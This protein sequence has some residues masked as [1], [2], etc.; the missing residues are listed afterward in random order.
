MGRPALKHE[1]HPDQALLD[2]CAQWKVN[3]QRWNTWPNDGDDAAFSAF[4]AEEVEP[5]FEQIA[6]TPATTLAG[7]QAKA[8]ILAIDSACDWSCEADSLV[9]IFTA[10]LCRELIAIGGRR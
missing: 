5:L 7:V 2:L 8:E 4:S 1:P 10:S 6:K 9:A 3:F